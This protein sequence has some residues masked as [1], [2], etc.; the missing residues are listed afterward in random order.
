MDSVTRD[1]LL[2]LAHAFYGAES[3]D[4]QPH[5]APALLVQAPEQAL[6]YGHLA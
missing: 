1:A 4:R 5:V 6:A 2:H 3:Y